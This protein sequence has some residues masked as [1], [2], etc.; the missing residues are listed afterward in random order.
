MSYTDLFSGK[1][2]DFASPFEIS[3]APNNVISNLNLFKI[4]HHQLNR[5]AIDTSIISDNLTAPEQPAYAQSAWGTARRP[6]FSTQLYGLRY[7][8]SLNSVTSRDLEQYRSHQIP[9][10]GDQITLALADFSAAQYSQ[11]QNS[12]ELAL[13]EALLDLKQDSDYAD[14]GNLDFLAG[15]AK[16][17]F[18]LDASDTANIFE[19]LTQINRIQSVTLG[20]GLAKQRRG[21]VILAAGKAASALRY[22][23]SISQ[24]MTYTLSVNNPDNFFT[25]VQTDNPGLESWQLNGVTVIDVTGIPSI[26]SRIGADGFVAIPLLDNNAFTLHS[27]VGTRHATQGKGAELV[28]QYV[29]VD[30]QFG[31]PSIC[32]ESSFLPFIPQVVAQ[33][34]VFGSLS[35]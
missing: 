9:D 1:M 6:E 20:E 13:C 28:H 27:G 12:I 26:A 31:F 19:Q 11:I 8:N 7:V 30:Q 22:H 35:A 32:S 29:V 4:E 15:G 14:Q 24:F 25:K 5:I 2:Y 34:I 18:T 33:S 17:Q 3:V 10:V 21:M 23:S 16:T